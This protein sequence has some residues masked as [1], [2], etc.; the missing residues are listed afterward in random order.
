MGRGTETRLS[1]LDKR[2]VSDVLVEWAEERFDCFRIRL[3]S[4]ESLA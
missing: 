3:G 4:L 2:Y 1:L